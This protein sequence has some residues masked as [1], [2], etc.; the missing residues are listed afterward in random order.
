MASSSFLS[1][2]VGAP[3]CASAYLEGIDAR[4]RRFT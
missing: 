1:V 4:E 2:I 3:S